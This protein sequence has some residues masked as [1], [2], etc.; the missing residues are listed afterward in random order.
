VK[1]LLIAYWSRPH[2]LQLM[3]ASMKSKDLEAAI[4]VMDTNEVGVEEETEAVAV[5]V[6]SS[7]EGVVVDLEDEVDEE[8]AVLRNH[9]S[10]PNTRWPF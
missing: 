2:R 9:D 8:A 4:V 7:E 5:T 3:M 6:V 1:F 10:N